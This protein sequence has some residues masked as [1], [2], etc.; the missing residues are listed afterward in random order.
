MLVFFLRFFVFFIVVVMFLFSLFDFFIFIIFSF[1]LPGTPL[2]RR[3]PPREW[4]GRGKKDENLGGPAKGE[5]RGERPNLG[6]SDAHRTDTPHNTTT[7][8]TT[9]DSA[10][11]GFGPPLA[12]VFWG[13]GWFSKVWAQ[14]TKRRSGP[15]GA[16]QMWSGKQKKHG[17]NK[18]QKQ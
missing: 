12:K 5:S 16:G 13:Q 18:N 10:Q 1:S 9:G 11:G 7:N 17:K 3:R 15:K 2:R 4:D 14:N 6:R 8:N